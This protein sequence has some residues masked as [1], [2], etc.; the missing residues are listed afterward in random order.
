MPREANPPGETARSPLDRLVETLVRLASTESPGAYKLCGA[1]VAL[2]VTVASAL[3]I[4]TG[5]LIQRR[6]G[7]DTPL[8][9]D[10]AWKVLWGYKPS[11]DFYCPF[12]IFE[13]VLVAAG[14]KLAGL[15]ANAIAVGNAIFGASAAALAW[16]SGRVR[17]SAALLLLFTLLVAFVALSAHQL[18]FPY[19]ETTYTTLYN[20]H[21][22]ALVALLSVLLCL[23]RRE[24]SPARDLREGI[25]V[26]AVW[27][28]VFFI[29]ITF[30]LVGAAFVA[31]ALVLFRPSRRWIIGALVG[32][33][34]VGLAFLAYL[35]FDL[36]A[37]LGDLS[38]AAAA[39]RGTLSLRT[40][41]SYLLSLNSQL[42]LLLLMA[43]LAVLS[44]LAPKAHGLRSSIQ[45]TLIGLTFV[46]CS[47]FIM[48]TN[49]PDGTIAEAPLVVV[50]ALLL[51]EA[52][53][54]FLARPST[55][56]VTRGLSPAVAMHFVLLLTGAM[57][58]G[59]VLLRDS[60]SVAYGVI[61][62]AVK[63]PSYG[64]SDRFNTPSMS[65]MIFTKVSGDPHYPGYGM[66]YAEK[67]NDGLKLLDAN[68]GRE[69][70]I[71]SFDF[72]NPFPFA[73]LRPPNPGGPI[74]WQLGFTFTA[75]RYPDVARTFDNA[76][77]IMI[78][79]FPGNPEAPQLLLRV[80]GDYIRQHFAFRAESAHW[81]L[82]TR[83]EAGSAT[84]ELDLAR[85]SDAIATDYA[86][87]HGYVPQ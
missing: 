17:F 54:R 50:P 18:R 87:L 59:R 78:P 85:I 31:V 71:E 30:F 19:Y 80:Y 28:L 12:G 22:Y 39:R 55:G 74:C 34:V 82:L 77:A 79:K 42:A 5:P 47:V 73:S 66:T 24:G 76:D 29:K 8:L 67:V 27:V 7:H 10:G 64:P 60:A 65:G 52:S 83:K 1:I 81:F 41:V 84:V 21:G 57:L 49:A 3:L 11:A 32:G 61:S 58:I 16:W 45:S 46:G 62:S 40:P 35:R 20:R 51:M 23:R 48:S 37:I 43:L 53:R 13:Y 25:C 69:T 9:L 2:V 26:G 75:A 4:I 44:P 15:T 72:T 70:R 63:G 14:L 86:E 6:Y 68:V 38:I 36:A 33:T 56:P